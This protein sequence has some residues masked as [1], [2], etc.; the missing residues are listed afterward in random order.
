MATTGSVV[1]VRANSVA[2][3]TGKTGSVSFFAA[4]ASTSIY[5]SLAIKRLNTKNRKVIRP[6][7]VPM[8]GTDGMPTQQWTDWFV[9]IEKEFLNMLNGPTLP[10]I[11]KYV[12]VGQATAI[13]VAAVQA[14]LAQQA[15]AN[16]QSIQTIREVVQTAALPGAA[17]I[18]PPKL[19]SDFTAP[20]NSTNTDS[21]G[22]E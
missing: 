22:G 7:G 8:V 21:R 16:A 19:Y 13:A 3:Q 6:V 11:T 14:G 18:P 17:Q 9:Y 5:S 10:D 15:N 4:R 20:G 12:T 1:Y 2:S